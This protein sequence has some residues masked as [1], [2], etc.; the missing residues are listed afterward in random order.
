MSFTNA[1]NKYDV[2]SRTTMKM[3]GE[4]KISIYYATKIFHCIQH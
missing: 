1:W 3:K 4:Q 2:R